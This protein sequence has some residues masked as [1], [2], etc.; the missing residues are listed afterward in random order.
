MLIDQSIGHFGIR[1]KLIIIIIIMGL[2][3]LGR[4]QLH[5]TNMILLVT[6]PQLIMVLWM[7]FDTYTLLHELGCNMLFDTNRYDS[8][9]DVQWSLQ[10]I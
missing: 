9:A 4:T 6:P 10:R 3:I 1:H 2:D 5:L 8:F 7:L